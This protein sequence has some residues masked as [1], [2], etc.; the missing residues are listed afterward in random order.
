[1]I[2]RRGVRS[3]VGMI[4]EGIWLYALARFTLGDQV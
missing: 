1:M 4:G 2:R 3:N